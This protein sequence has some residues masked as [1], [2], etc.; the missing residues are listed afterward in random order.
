MEQKS[1]SPAQK[2]EAS[3]IP[4]GS[5]NTDWMCLIGGEIKHI[6]HFNTKETGSGI[7]MVVTNNEKDYTF[8]F[9]LPEGANPLD[10]IDIKHWDD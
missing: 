9:V 7:S 8:H 1:Q 10:H 6:M 5:R 2:D 3:S 4:A